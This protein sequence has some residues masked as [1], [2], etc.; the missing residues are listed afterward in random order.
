MKARALLA[1]TIVACAPYARAPTAPAVAT[2]LASGV[3]V[4]LPHWFQA[5]FPGP[6][7]ESRAEVNT[8]AGT[9][10]FRQFAGKSATLWAE[11]RVVESPGGFSTS[12]E[13]LLAARAGKPLDQGALLHQGA[14]LGA[15]TRLVAP[16]HSRDNPSA[17]TIACRLREYVSDTKLVIALFCGGP[18]DPAVDRAADSLRVLE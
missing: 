7:D 6:V 8:D 4:T 11:V 1:A 2:P 13:N 12:K 16:P 10:P 5:D 17:F 3:R 14:F 15:D 9:L 18:R